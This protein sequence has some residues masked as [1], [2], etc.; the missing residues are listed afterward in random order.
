MNDVASLG[1]TIV[2]K[3]DQLNADDLLVGPITVEVVDVKRGD[4]QEQ[5]ISIKIDGGRQPYKPCKSMRRVLIA[6]WGDDGKKW[7]GHRMTLYCDPE[8]KFGGV[9]VGGIRISHMTGIRGRMAV[10]LTTTR[11]KRSEYLVEELA[12]GATPIDWDSH[13]KPINEA[14]TMDALA[15]AFASAQEVA[16]TAKDKQALARIVASKDARKAQLAQ[17]A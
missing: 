11:S 6:A 16:K 3:S 17:S 1:D 15:K 4:T 12:Q 14:A 9:K 8:V 10:M 7:I 5:P 13:I 2:P